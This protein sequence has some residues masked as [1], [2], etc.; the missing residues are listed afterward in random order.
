MS[1]KPLKNKKDITQQQQKQQKKQQEEEEKEKDQNIN[2]QKYH[3]RI[4]NIEYDAIRTHHFA[5]IMVHHQ[6]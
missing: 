3:R 1:Q 5:V 2:K 6:T 4:K